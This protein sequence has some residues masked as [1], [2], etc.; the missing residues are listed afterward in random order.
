MFGT[1]LKVIEAISEH[2]L[3]VYYHVL[4]KCNQFWIMPKR[5]SRS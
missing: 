1:V 5:C 3:K 4:A 2:V